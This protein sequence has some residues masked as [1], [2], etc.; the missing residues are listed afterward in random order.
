M[1]HSPSAAAVLSMTLEQYIDLASA[2]CKGQETVQKVPVLEEA[3]YKTSDLKQVGGPLP[4][5]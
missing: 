4:R 2:L 5:P 3:Y 1:S